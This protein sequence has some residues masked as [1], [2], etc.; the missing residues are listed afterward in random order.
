MAAELRRENSYTII[1]AMHPGEVATWVGHF[2]S[3]T[4]FSCNHG[5]SDGAGASLGSE[6]D[7]IISTEQSVS[8]MLQV[9]S[10]KTLKDTGTFWTWE[11]KVNQTTSQVFRSWHFQRYPWWDSGKTHG[12]TGLDPLCPM[13]NIKSETSVKSF[14][15]KYPLATFTSLELTQTLTKANHILQQIFIPCFISS[16]T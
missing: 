5:R 8:A 9:I 13:T 7:G 12:V 4:Q 16:A 11:G 6:V 15:R 3:I 1:L 2:P 14:L 10:T